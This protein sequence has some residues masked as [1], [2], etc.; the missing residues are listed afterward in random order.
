[1]IA[2]VA[3]IA[4]ALSAAS[5]TAPARLALSVSPTHLAVQAGGRATIRVAPVPG[6]RLV[7]RTGVVG[8]TLDRRGRP[9]I[10]RARDAAA[11]LTVRPRTVAAGRAGTAF[12]VT[13]RRAPG[14]RPGDHTAIVLVTAL[15]PTG[16]G[17]AVG[18][19]VGLVV[20][21]RVPGP[22][23]RRVEVVAARARPG[24]RLIDVTVANRGGRIESIGGAQLAVTLIRRGRVI[25]RFRVA[26][27]PLLP[28]TRA[29]FTIR[30]RTVRGALVA[31]VAIV[32]PDGRT[33]ARRFPLRL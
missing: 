24:G 2:G 18:M 3:L 31:Q 30:C 4:A 9:Q 17:I 6:G 1:M 11:W 21:V 5:G 26:R 23:L 13:S 27:R 15:A 33:A 19:R 8:L 22:S 7:L 20:T 28:H 32:R 14:A 12:V 16:N 29:V 10:V 25:G